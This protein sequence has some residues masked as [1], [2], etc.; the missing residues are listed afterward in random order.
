VSFAAHF[1][2]VVAVYT[3]LESRIPHI[4]AGAAGRQFVQETY[5]KLGLALKILTKS[6]K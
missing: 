4:P 6:A 3:T 1:V 5:P 2:S